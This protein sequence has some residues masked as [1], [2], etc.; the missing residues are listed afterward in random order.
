MEIL[1]KRMAIK[2]F[3]PF[4]IKKKK[5]ISNKKPKDPLEP[6]KSAWFVTINTNQDDD[7]LIKPLHVVLDWILSHIMSFVFGRGYITSVTEAHRVI[8]KGRFRRV[9]LHTKIEIASNGIAFLDVVKITNFINKQLFQ[10]PTFKG[11]Y[12]NAALIKNYNHSTRIEKYTQ[13]DPYISTIED[14][15]NFVILE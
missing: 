7:R 12:F 10:F 5:Y 8:E 15:S 9:H 6:W 2:K 3:N 14:D 11:V 1:D 4:K 13:K